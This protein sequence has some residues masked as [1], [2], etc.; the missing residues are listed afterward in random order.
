MRTKNILAATFLALG[1]VAGSAQAA[2]VAGGQCS[3]YVNGASYPSLSTANVTL[4]GL[5]ASDCYGSVANATFGSNSP[6]KV[7][8]FA[9]D[10]P[11]F[12]GGW[13]GILRYDQAGDI[14]GYQ[15]L[16]FTLT[17]LQF[18][19][20]DTS[21]TLRLVDQNLAAPPS[22]PVTMDLLF[23]LKGATSTDFFFFDDIVLDASNGGSYRMSIVNGGGQ[24]PTLSDITLAGRDLRDDQQCSQDDPTCVPQQVVPEPATLLLAS[25][26]LLGAGLVR[27]RRS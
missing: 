5:A 21:F 7:L 15:G 23:T 13:D 3:N 25:A 6:Q 2:V 8:Q 20:E 14:G 1:F 18:G 19:Q 24:I 12:G 9:N 4:N 22:L 16:L 17:D 11:A 26:A 27:R 10:A